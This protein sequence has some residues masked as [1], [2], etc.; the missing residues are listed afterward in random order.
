MSEPIVDALRTYGPMTSGEI[1][2]RVGRPVTNVRR[3][4]W[5]LTKYNLVRTTGYTVNPE[6]N[7]KCRLWEA[8]F[9]EKEE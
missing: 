3:K 8:V 6:T 7:M 5:T 1:A 2:K 9:E 4:L